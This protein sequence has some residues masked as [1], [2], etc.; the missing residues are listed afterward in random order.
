MKKRVESD[1][2]SSDTDD[3]KS[4]AS[5][6]KSREDK[7]KQKK[8]TKDGPKRG[9]GRPKK[10]PK[11]ELPFRGI[12]EEPRNK[13]HVVEF[14]YGEPG[15]FKRMWQFF[16]LMSADKIQFLF[17]PDDIFV[18]GIDHHRKSKLLVTINPNNL[19]EYYCASPVEICLSDKNLEAIM[20]KIDKTQ[21]SIKILVPKSDLTICSVSFILTNNLDIATRDI[22][23]VGADKIN[24]FDEKEFDDGGYTIAFT[25][26]GKYFKKMITDVKSISNK[27]MIKQD[28]PDSPLVFEHVGRGNSVATEITFNDSRVIN[29]SSKLQNDESFCISLVVDYIKPI[30][31]ALANSA[32]CIS[33]DEDK[34][35]LSII[36]LNEI[37]EVRVLTEIIDAR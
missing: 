21:E 14:L 1:S 3:E 37:F 29:F 22:V 17:T 2:S 32:I 19:N 16:K 25:L 4:S 20:N 34:P 23:D 35:F 36:K 28:S 8:V 15:V 5:E 27:L 11:K 18:W 7:K 24:M 9:P 31:S 33:V 6:K 30:G 12:L 26:P 13:A 10:V